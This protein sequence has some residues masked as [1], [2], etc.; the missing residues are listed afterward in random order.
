M[1]MVADGKKN[2]ILEN[3]KLFPEDE[4]NELVKF[5]IDKFVARK[6]TYSQATYVLQETED[7]LANIS[8]MEI[9]L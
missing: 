9:E 4:V 7:V 6:L 8:I 2:K 5:I 3:G 1:I